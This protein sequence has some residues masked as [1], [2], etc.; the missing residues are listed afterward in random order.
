MIPRKRS[1]SKAG[2]FIAS[3]LV[4]S[5]SGG[6]NAF[7]CQ[8]SFNIAARPCLSKSKCGV[9]TDPKQIMHM[10]L[11]DKD[12]FDRRLLEDIYL[13]ASTDS[14]GLSGDMVEGL[15]T[16]RPSQVRSVTKIK[17]ARQ[18]T[19][20]DMKELVTAKGS[21]RLQFKGLT[22]GPDGRLKRNSLSRTPPEPR[23]STISRS[24]TMPGFSERARTDSMRAYTDGVKLAERLSGKQFKDS[25]EV[26]ERR[27]AKNGESMYKSSASVPESLVD[28]AKKIHEIDRITPKEEVMLGEKTQ[29]AVRLQKIY[30]T[31]QST[32]ARE[33]T[34]EEWCAAS[35]KINMEHL[36]QAIEEGLEAKNKLVTSNLRMVQGVVNVY[37]RNGLRGQY[38]AGD[39]MQEGVMVSH[40]TWELSPFR[41]SLCVPFSVA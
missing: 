15:P 38:N 26:K 27:R 24:S 1:Y 3:A 37:I 33:P 23:S 31:L 21:T 28:F 4:L 8:T 7:Q 10:D 32:L 39:L 20:S 35:G 30:D 19:G 18:V 29:E 40:R 9:V 34:D 6:S 2:F 12:G 5:F 16:K 14:G 13:I 22:T 17:T 41:R 25:V 36:S 11:D